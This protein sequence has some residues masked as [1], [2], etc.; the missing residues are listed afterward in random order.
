[1]VRV[2]VGWLVHMVGLL[3]GR[4]VGQLVGELVGWRFVM[5]NIGDKM[6]HD[7]IC[8]MDAISIL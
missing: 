3:G 2:L 7:Y 5:N 6:C 8:N 1:M 4:L